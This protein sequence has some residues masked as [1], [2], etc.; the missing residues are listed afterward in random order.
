MI[1][2]ENDNCA[3]KKHESII[4]TLTDQNASLKEENDCLKEE[5]IRLRQT[6][7]KEAQNIAKIQARNLE[8]EDEVLVLWQSVKS[9]NMR[10]GIKLK[11]ESCSSRKDSGLETDSCNSRSHP[12]TSSGASFLPCFTPGVSGEWKRQKHQLLPSEGDSTN[13]PVSSLGDQVIPTSSPGVS[14]IT[15][16]D[17]LKTLDTQRPQDKS[18]RI[19]PEPSNHAHDE[20]IVINSDSDEDDLIIIPSGGESLLNKFQ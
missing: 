1:H 9:T 15:S 16:S 6:L 18:S 5:N 12:T 17:S 19:K 3:R 20:E 14:T 2:N 4:E 7:D 11:D 10:S 13:K 8:L